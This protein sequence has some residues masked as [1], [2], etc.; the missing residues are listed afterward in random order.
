MIALKDISGQH[1]V[2]FPQLGP[3][4]DGLGILVHEI[5]VHGLHHGVQAQALRLDGHLHIFGIHGSLAGF[6]V[7]VPFPGKHVRIVVD[8]LL[9]RHP[10]LGT[11]LLVRDEGG[12]P[13]ELIQLG[14]VPLQEQ[15]QVP[16]IDELG[17]VRDDGA[18]KAVV[19]LITPQLCLPVVVSGNIDALQPERVFQY[20]HV[21]IKA[22]LPSGVLHLLRNHHLELQV[23][24][25]VA[26]GHVAEAGCHA[27]GFQ[28]VRSHHVSVLVL[29]GFH[30][31]Y[32]VSFRILHHQRVPVRGRCPEIQFRQEF[33]LLA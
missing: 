19:L 33:L 27:G 29:D 32:V 18:D 10:E 3:R 15:L 1:D 24:P 14:D 31:E 5:S 28:N 9:L 20:K 4:G 17:C 8:G 23:N 30:N 13:L 11:E 6:P 21:G 2:H 22:E 12:V 26:F 16:Q 7:F 25:A